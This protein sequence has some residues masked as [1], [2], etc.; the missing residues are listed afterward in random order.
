[1]TTHPT[2]LEGIPA[3]LPFFGGGAPEGNDLLG[4]TLNTISHPDSFKTVEIRFSATVTQ[5]AYRYLRLEVQS[6]G[7]A[8]PQGRY[9]PYA[10]HWDVPFTV[11]DADNNVQLDVA[12][13]ERGLTDDAGVLSPD[14]TTVSTYDRTWGPDESA[15]GGREYLLVFNR[16]Y[17]PTPK[18]ALRL[19]NVLPMGGFPVLYAL[20]S[21]RFTNADVFDEGDAFRFLWGPPSS[22][23]AD[24]LLV[25]LEGRSLDD[26]SVQAA[27]QALIDCLS[28]INMGIGIGETC[29][30]GPTPTLVSLV[31]SEV[32]IDR[33]VLRWYVAESGFRAAVE[34]RALGKEWTAVGRVSADGS[35]HL[36]FEDRDVSPGAVYDYRLAFDGADGLEHGGEARVEV[37]LNALLAFLGTRVGPG[38][39]RLTVML[40]LATRE[41]ARIE[42]LDV[43]G[44]RLAARDLADLDPGGHEI[45]LEA[46]GRLPAGIYLVRIM[47]GGRRV[48]GKAAIV[49]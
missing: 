21:R 38:D 36:D 27:Y 46:S 35:G 13:V 10:G 41:P 9:Y 4:S 32:S 11:W 14:S 26:P 30:S 12:F 24:S 15:V 7:G 45:D 19:D 44:R 5:K 43:A 6:T 17:S 37:P 40:S 48:A 34:R 31:G 16:P 8:P 18:D 42:V 47:Q 28:Q 23:G 49:R 22:P 2:P 1:M 3:G 39:R 25:D 33:V 20:W 29:D